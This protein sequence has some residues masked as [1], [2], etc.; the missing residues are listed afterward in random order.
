MPKFIKLSLHDAES[1]SDLYDAAE[2]SL[3]NWC[4]EVKSLDEIE[5]RAL[6]LA[7]ALIWTARQHGWD[8]LTKSPK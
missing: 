4:G 3:P 7:R 2:G 1:R 5:E 6:E 8:D